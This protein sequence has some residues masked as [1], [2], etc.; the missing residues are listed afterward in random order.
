MCAYVRVNKSVR[1][2]CAVPPPP[3]FGLNHKNGFCA[4]NIPPA[5]R[6]ITFRRTPRPAK[7]IY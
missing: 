1:P 4:K 7:V 3:F 6:L 5:H 2:Q